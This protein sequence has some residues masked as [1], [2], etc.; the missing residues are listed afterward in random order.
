M[1]TDQ[2]QCIDGIYTNALDEVSKCTM[3]YLIFMHRQLNFYLYSL[4]MT[5]IPCIIYSFNI[6]P[7]NSLFSETIIWLLPTYVIPTITGEVTSVQIKTFIYHIT[8]GG[9]TRIF[10]RLYYHTRLYTTRAMHGTGCVQNY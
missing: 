6:K 5:R 7:I 1:Y 3:E 2:V 10:V 8:E 9:V 4:F